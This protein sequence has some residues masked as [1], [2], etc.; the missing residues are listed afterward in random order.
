MTRA[1]LIQV[2]R[3]DFLDDISDAQAGT[4]LVVQAVS[5]T[6]LLR[7]LLEG[8]R[9]AC[10]RTDDLILDG[11]SFELRLATG[12]QSYDLDPGILRIKAVRHGTA[13]LEHTT[14]AALDRDVSGWRDYA[15]GAPTAFYLTRHRLTLDR[16]PSAAENGTHLGLAVWREPLDGGTLDEEPEIPAQMHRDL[17]AWAAYR[18]FLLPDPHIRDDARALYFLQQFEAV[19]GPPRT[20][21]LLTFKL[22][23]PGWS[24]IGTGGYSSAWPATTT[25]DELTSF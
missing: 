15:A 14:E 12:V 7:W 4:D 19:F 20:A 11:T 23:D 24:D 2:V 3:E 8:E 21:A 1:E 16:A 6:R 17:I 22:E 25:T 5:D 10:R 18:Y 9:E 13:L